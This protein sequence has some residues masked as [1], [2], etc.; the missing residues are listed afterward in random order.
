MAPVSRRRPVVPGVGS[1][2]PDR[3]AT[4]RAADG[5][6]TGSVPHGLLHHVRCPVVT[7]PRPTGH[8]NP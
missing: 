4:T 8:P 7:V 1:R 3:L 5:M 6:R 2:G